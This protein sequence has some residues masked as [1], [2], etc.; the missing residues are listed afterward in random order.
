MTIIIL[1]KSNL[2]EPHLLDIFLFYFESM[3]MTILLSIEFNRTSAF[4]HYSILHLESIE[5]DLIVKKAP[6]LGHL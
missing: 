3:R 6:F 5:D 4:R 1:S 2:I